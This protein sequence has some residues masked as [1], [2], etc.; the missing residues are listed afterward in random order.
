MRPARMNRRDS[1]IREA[2]STD[3]AGTRSSNL[4]LES[5]AMATELRSGWGMFGRRSVVWMTA[6]VVLGSSVAAGPP[7]G[8]LPEGGQAPGQATAVARNAAP[9]A[10]SPRRAAASDRTSAGALPDSV[11]AR[12]GRGREITRSDAVRRWRDA[13]PSA[14]ADSITPTAAREFLDL[15][16]DEA[17]LTEAAVQE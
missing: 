15:L 6:G 8:A 2:E 13:H 7:A 11:L 3:G 14:V 1:R 9:V 4:M 12:V 10:H 17:A 5:P 16:V